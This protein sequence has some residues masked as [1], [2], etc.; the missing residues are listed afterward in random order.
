MWPSSVNN[1]SYNADPSFDPM[2]SGYE[3]EALQPGDVTATGQAISQGA[4]YAATYAGH[5][6]Q[7]GIS[8]IVS[9]V[10]WWVWGLGA[11]YAIK[12]LTNAKKE[13]IDR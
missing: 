10:P 1:P 13:F 12:V 9:L 11:L 7:S 2:G 8:K 6:V 4:T 3:G 5:A